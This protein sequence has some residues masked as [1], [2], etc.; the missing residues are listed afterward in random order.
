MEEILPTDGEDAT[1][2]R[3]TPEADGEEVAAKTAAVSV[4]LQETKAF[5]TPKQIL[6]AIVDTAA[7]KA[8][9]ATPDLLL[10]GFLAGAY[11]SFG[12]ALMF[13][14]NSN[15]GGLREAGMGGLATLIAA[16]VFPVCFVIHVLAGSEL[17]TGNCAV[18][19]AG[20]L[21][22]KCTWVQTIRHWTLAFLGNFAGAL[23]VAYFLIFQAGLAN[24]ALSAFL[25]KLAAVK[26]SLSFNEAFLRGVGANWLVCLAVLL[27]QSAMSVPGKILGAW[28]PIMAFVAIGFEHSVANMFAIPLAYMTNAASFMEF[29]DLF[30]NF[31]QKNLLPVTLGNIVGGL[32]F[33]GMFYN[34]ILLKPQMK[35]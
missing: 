2:K 3:E 19:G 31:L 29:K 9:T 15:L 22:G 18:L 34:R 14:I 17:W 1:G 24:E 6:T 5:N 11:I 28:F 12:G 8:K 25:G 13:T 35:V 20:A 27:V 23:T 26:T 21:Q 16:S 7:L 30:L 32:V 10:S 33:V 4:G